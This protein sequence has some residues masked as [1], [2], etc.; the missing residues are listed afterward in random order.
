MEFWEKVR[1]LRCSRF[2]VNVVDFKLTLSDFEKKSLRVFS[3]LNEF[4]SKLK[5]ISSIL[6]KIV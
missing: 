2:R 3:K 1:D 5:E 6:S 4:S